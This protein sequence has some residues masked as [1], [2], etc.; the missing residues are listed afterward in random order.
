MAMRCCIDQ[1]LA[2]WAP[3]MAADHVGAG[4]GLVEEHERDWIHEPLPDPPVLAVLGH[5]RP[6]LF[7]CPH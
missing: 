5:V 4:A 6:V 7:G 2:A 3:A 1:A